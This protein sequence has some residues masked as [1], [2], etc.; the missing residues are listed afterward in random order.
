MLEL[1]SIIAQLGGSK[2][3]EKVV[4]SYYSLEAYAPSTSP[5]VPQLLKNAHYLWSN[6]HLPE[7][8][9]LLVSSDRI[10]KAL[11]AVA[12]AQIGEYEDLKAI[13]NYIVAE[14]WPIHE[15]RFWLAR[16]TGHLFTSRDLIWLKELL[17][18]DYG[19]QCVASSVLP[20]LCLTLSEEALLEMLNEPIIVF[21]INAIGGLVAIGNPEILKKH[22][23]LLTSTDIS[24]RRMMAIGLTA[25]G[26]WEEIDQL[27]QIDDF[28]LHEGVA[29][30]L[31]YVKH[32]PVFETLLKLVDDSEANLKACE[33]LALIGDE[34]MLQS[35]VD[36]L[37]KH[38]YD[39]NADIMKD[40]LIHLDRR[41]YCP[42]EW[43][44]K[45]ERDFSNLRYSVRRYE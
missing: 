32:G 6:D 45:M 13:V 16:K 34:N 42:I 10:S 17:N 26:D 39:P 28:G 44:S 27:L 20:V 19:S 21:K 43:A 18:G 30:G 2:V 40:I 7:L 22:K 9:K 36:W 3:Q 37:I 11:A 4:A 41:Q 15:E 24:L 1:L 12:L 14:Q 31:R 25:T 38:P 23:Y 5:L 35:I 33:S 8:R 29:E